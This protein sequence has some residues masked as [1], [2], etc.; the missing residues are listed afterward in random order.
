MLMDLKYIFH[1]FLRPFEDAVILS[2]Y[3]S[4]PVSSAGVETAAPSI[5][6]T[7]PYPSQPNA[8]P[9]RPATLT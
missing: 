8:L 4:M 5:H 9:T 6:N 1:G 7:T 3:S 2:P